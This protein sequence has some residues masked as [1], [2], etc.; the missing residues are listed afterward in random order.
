MHATSPKCRIYLSCFVRKSWLQQQQLPILP[1]PPCW[2][3]LI[4][5]LFLWMLMSWAFNIELYDVHCLWHI[6]LLWSV[7]P[8]TGALLFKWEAI[9]QYVDEPCI[10][11]HHQLLDIWNGHL[12]WIM[13]LGTFVCKFLWE[14]VFLSFFVMYLEIEILDN[15]LT[16]C[17]LLRNIC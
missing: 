6:L 12:S 5:L 17:T 1:F 11:I 10:F 7:L 2:Q 16:R 14:N 9:L 15:T 8:C 3:L 13:L 4:C